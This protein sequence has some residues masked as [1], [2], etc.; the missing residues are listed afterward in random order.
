M[1]T[2]GARA[3]WEPLRSLAFGGISGTYAAIG[4]AT[5]S[6]T[7]MLSITNTTDALL[8]FSF[9]GSTNIVVIPAY[10]ARI[11]DIGSNT[12]DD[13]S[14]PANTTF[15]VKGAPTAG[16]VYVEVTYAG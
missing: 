11:W 6:P 9:N 4:T 12:I 3:L 14:L 1:A 7:L 16:A 13:F 10:T 5:A 15:Y 2:V 8:T